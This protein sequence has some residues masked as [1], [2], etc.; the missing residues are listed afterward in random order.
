MMRRRLAFLLIASLALGLLPVLPRPAFSAAPVVVIGGR[1]VFKVA[2]WLGQELLA[3]AAAGAGE[4]MGRRAV[5]FVLDRETGQKFN[6]QLQQRETEIGTKIRRV[7]TPEQARLQTELEVIRS[8]REMIQ[9]L[10][11]STPRPEDLARF[12]RQVKNDLDKIADILEEHEERIGDLEYEVAAL[13]A[14]LEA[15]EEVAPITMLKDAD[16]F[17]EAVAAVNLEVTAGLQLTFQVE[18]GDA[19]IRTWRRG[20]PRASLNGRANEYDP[21][22]KGSKVLYLAGD[23]EYLVT[24]IHD[25]LP[26]YRI[27]VRASELEDPK[28]FRVRL[29]KTR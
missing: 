8:Q 18:P 2:K 15:L 17:D 4:E 1:L 28:T 12:R 9:S 14:Q 23:G 7:S 20:E 13:Q 21:R 11:K 5:G 29:G 6:Q 3:G 27:L 19:F 22:K 25:T 26:S 24:I 10:L 16:R